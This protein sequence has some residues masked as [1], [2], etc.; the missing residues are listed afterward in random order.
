MADDTDLEVN[1]DEIDRL[2]AEDAAK[3]AP[4]VD[5]AGAKVDKADDIVVEK[6]EKTPPKA[7]K[8]VLTADEGLA[9][10]QKQLEDEKAAREAEKRR[11]DD[12]E[13]HAREASEGERLARTEKQATELDLVTNAISTVTQANDALEAKYAEALGAQDYAGAAKIQR[14]MT[15]NSA[16][17]LQLENGKAALEK[18][19]KPQARA[20]VDAVEEFISRIGPEY[21][22]SREWLRAHPEFARDA[23]K[24]RQ[25]LAA[26]ELAMSRDLKADSD[27]YF[28]SIESTLNLAKPVPNGKGAPHDD[29]PMADAA[30]EIEVTPEPRP[31]RAAP[32]AAPVSRSG[33]GTGSKPNTVRLT[34]AQQEAA[35]I[36]GVSLEEYARQLKKIERDEQG[37]LN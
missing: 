12:A 22:R 17:L 11:A 8:P 1:F 32:A 26:H 16:N 28:A 35:E 9:K 2:K 33:G 18:A 7:E 36:S 14:E 29:D 10:L 5:K 25:M 37:K 3:N 27:E 21:P 20:P 19:P 24:N 30:Q 6:V 31:R 23:K 4:K 34:P 15:K 13:R